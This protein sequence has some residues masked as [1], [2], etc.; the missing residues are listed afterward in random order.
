MARGWLAYGQIVVVK[1]GLFVLK[2]AIHWRAELGKYWSGQAYSEGNQYVG[3][4][5]HPPVPNRVVM[6]SRLRKDSDSYIYPWTGL[7]P[8]LALSDFELRPSGCWGKAK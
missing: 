7:G 8:A 4:R 5:Q 2:I 3:F 6:I 1:Y